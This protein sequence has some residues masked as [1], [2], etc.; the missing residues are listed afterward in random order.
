MSGVA[1]TAAVLLPAPRASVDDVAVTVLPGLFVPEASQWLWATS[2]RV[3]LEGYS[4]MQAVHW[5]AGSGLYEPRRYRSHGP[6]SFGVTTVR[7]AQEL[8]QLS[9]CRPGIKYLMR[10][11]GL[12]ER[13]VQDHLRMLRETGLLAYVVKGTRV[14]EEGGQASE[15]A[16]MVPP[17]FDVALGIRTVLRDEA[18][19]AYTRAMT[20]IADAGRGLMA[21]LAR[22]ASRK[23]RKPRKAAPGTPKPARARAAGASETAVSGEAR[24]TPM[25]VGSSSSS[26]AATTSL[27][28][29]PTGIASGKSELSIR[30]VSGDKARR[31]VNTVGRRYQLASELIREIP[32]LG[33]AST[34]RI[35]WV[36]RHVAD[37]GWSA[38]EVQGWL[39]ARGEVDTVHRASGLLATL[40]TG[41]HEIVSTPQARAGLVSDWRD[42]RIAAARRHQELEAVPQGPRSQ[43]AKA[44]WLRYDT[45]RQA[46]PA[47]YDKNSGTV[48]D[49]H[50]GHAMSAQE[51]EQM[52][53]LAKEEYSNGKND[54][55]RVIITSSGRGAA[56]VIFG[57]ELVHR[58]LNIP[59]P[60][61]PM[62]TANRW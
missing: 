40:L 25:Q 51:V 35:A 53:A 10:R 36:V 38:A 4:W 12:S 37:A 59:R 56:E 9:P 54:L 41:A 49:R 3:A 21:K 2:G 48:A 22:K 44:E 29:E 19:P 46:L 16:L 50:T 7:V 14:A 5:V 33:R 39:H 55:V 6:R 45:V 11:V 57:A 15:F 26:S 58:A 60:T 20:G 8:A 13:A 43:A 30:K 52:R 1:A 34:P 27:P 32:W 61:R 23:V 31:G 47:D 42:S 17:A 24:C 28:S 18:A 62:A